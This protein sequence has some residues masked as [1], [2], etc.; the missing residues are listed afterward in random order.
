MVA[1]K[2]GRCGIGIELN[3]EYMEIARRR[4]GEVESEVDS[5]TRFFAGAS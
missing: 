1:L 2:L 3:P 5:E 4:V